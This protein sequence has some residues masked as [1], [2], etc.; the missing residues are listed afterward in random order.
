MLAA[1]Y[2]A[3]DGAIDPGAVYA[4]YLNGTAVQGSTLTGDFTAFNGLPVAG[5]WTLNVK[6][7]GPG[8]GYYRLD[9]RFVFTYGIGYYTGFDF[10]VTPGTPITGRIALEG[11]TDLSAVHAPLG[12]FHVSFRTP[13]TT[14]ALYSQDV[15][16]IPVGA[17]S[18]YGAYAVTGVLAGTYDV[19]ITGSKQLRVVLPSVTV[20]GSATALP[21]VLLPGG[22]ADSNNTVD[23]GDFGVLV[24]AYGGILGA[25]GSNYDPQADF[26]YDGSVD[27][28][29]FGIL[30][31]EYGNSSPL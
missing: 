22:N 19:A 27:I 6:S 8:Y 29:D 31:N 9:H 20:G 25:A 28:A 3:Y 23:I 14:T 18:P 26:N 30:V 15:T 21:N 2:T 24:N 10:T 17:G 1:A 13:G 12:V 7:Y 11:V 5:D 16:L 4:P